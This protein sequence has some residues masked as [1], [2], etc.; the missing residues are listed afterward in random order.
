MKTKHKTQKTASKTT[1]RRKSQ[2][3][4]TEKQ[5]PGYPLYNPS[6]DITNK[7][8]RLDADI[9][10]TTLLNNKTKPKITNQPNKITNGGD[11]VEGNGDEGDESPADPYAVTKADLEVLGTDELNGDEGDDEGLKHRDN[12]VDFSGEDLDVPGNELD[13]DAEAIGSEDEEN[14]SYSLGGE[15]HNDLEED[16]S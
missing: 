10:D 9:E 8:K 2:V 4:K 13:D 3:K 6:E 12:P 15:N 14:N 11:G 16:P 1:S 5:F 7:G